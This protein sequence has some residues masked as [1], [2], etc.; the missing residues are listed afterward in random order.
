MCHSCW[1][2]HMTPKWKAFECGVVIGRR[3]IAKK[4]LEEWANGDISN[5]Y[6]TPFQS[7]ENMLLSNLRYI[8]E[9]LPYDS[10]F[11]TD[12]CKTWCN[13][14]WPKTAVEEV[15]VYECVEQA[16]REHKVP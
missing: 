15:S 3:A 2:G 16:I 4:R 12:E 5:W 14:A 10:W 6:I 8:N 11:E 7:F 1:Y 13:A 9:L